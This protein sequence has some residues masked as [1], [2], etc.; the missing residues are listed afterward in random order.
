MKSKILGV[1]LL[2]AGLIALTMPGQSQKNSE[3]A[4]E[5]IHKQRELPI[6]DFPEKGSTLESLSSKQKLK[7]SRYDRQSS[8]PI[9]EAYMIIGPYVV[10]RLVQGPP[11]LT[12]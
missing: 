10:N 11:G 7:G 8:E 9:R 2:V 12:F 5:V 6:V 1:L 4:K 3:L